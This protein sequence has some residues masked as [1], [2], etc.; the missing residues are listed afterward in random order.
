MELPE[1]LSTISLP[2]LARSREGGAKALGLCRSR[3]KV[4][5]AMGG[6]DFRRG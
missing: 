2:L 4:T 3:T 6:K 1:R 5:L